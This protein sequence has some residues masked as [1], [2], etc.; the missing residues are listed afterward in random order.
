MI[1]LLV[2][3]FSYFA[4]RR[5]ERLS[6]E[7]RK[8]STAAIAKDE[9][10]IDDDFFQKLRQMRLELQSQRHIAQRADCHQRDLPWLG[11]CHVNDKLCGRTRVQLGGGGYPAWQITQPICAMN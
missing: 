1:A 8:A 9:T 3:L 10:L 4:M 5:L 2:A 11:A 7:P 6:A